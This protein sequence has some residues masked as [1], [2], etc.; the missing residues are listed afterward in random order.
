LLGAFLYA[1]YPQPVVGSLAMAQPPA[2]NTLILEP[3][4]EEKAKALETSPAVLGSQTVEAEG[5]DA[6]TPDDREPTYLMQ[7]LLCAVASLEGAD[8]VLLGASMGALIDDKIL[9][10]TDVSYMTI[11]QM[12]LT[13]LAAPFWGILA[14]R[15]IMKR[16][17]ILLVGALGQGFVTILL[18]FVTSMLPM[19]FLRAL[20]GALLAALR[21]ISNGIVADMT[22]ESKRG[23]IF[24][25]IQ[26]ALLLGMFVTNMTVVPLAPAKNVWGTHGWR[27]AY[28]I[29]GSVSVLV[30]A[31]VT[32]FMREPPRAEEARD[33]GAGGRGG[34]CAAAASEV[35][36]LLK[37]FRMPTFCVMILQ[38][39]FGTIPWTVMGYQTLFFQ[40][41]GMHNGLVGFLT[42]IGPVTGAAGNIIGGMVADGL[43]RRFHLHGR[44]LSAQLTVAFGV[45]LMYLIFMVVPMEKDSFGMYL[46]LSIAFG[47]LGSW[48]Q[49]GTNF[50]IL[51]HIVPSQAR[52]RILAWECA[53]ENS[54][55]NAVGPLVVSLI[56]EKAFGYDLGADSGT[57][58][59]KDAARALGRALAA[60]I[61]IPW[62][63]DFFLYSLLHWTYPRDVRRLERRAQLQQEATP[64][65]DAVVS[66][67]VPSA[68][69]P[70]AE[71]DDGGHG[72][73]VVATEENLVSI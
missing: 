5:V 1:G 71:A 2:D 60:T 11:S 45:P 48:A 44:P 4:P 30:S 51:S 22:A 41:E 70:C 63:I 65:A 29:V 62:T 15:G 9:K 35:G 69:K 20:N 25:R 50:P 8:T 64:A 57:S 49:S 39:I 37:F 66:A 58:E 16:R 12:V 27:V 28:V 7:G 52:S 23:K 55:A 54:I 34:G 42:S 68:V 61:C 6:A 10:L 56:A 73:K 46:A 36:N 53:L 14:D 38:G 59:D 31:L 43:A 26:S 32:A 18:A 21:P 72:P 33:C 13:N 40:K 17:T 67:E 24:G 19:I 47:L 3:L